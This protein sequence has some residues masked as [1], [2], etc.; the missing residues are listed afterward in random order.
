MVNF[1]PETGALSLDERFRD[2][3]SGEAGVSLD[4]KTWPH[5]FQG[6]AY[7][8]GVVFSRA[9]TTAKAVT[10]GSQ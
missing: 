8:H 4:G 5:G 1:K 3:G 6:D 7:P 9:E 10:A 2:A